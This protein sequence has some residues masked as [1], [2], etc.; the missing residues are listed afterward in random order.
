VVHCRYAHRAEPVCVLARC[1]SLFVRHGRARQL[2]RGAESCGGILCAARSRFC[3]RPLYR[4]R[5][6]RSNSGTSSRG[7]YRIAFRLAACL[8]FHGRCWPALAG[9]LARDLWGLKSQSRSSTRI[10]SRTSVE[11]SPAPPANLAASDSTRPH[12]SRLVLLS[13]LVSEVF[14]GR[15]P[16]IPSINRQ[17]CLGGVSGGGYWMLGRRLFFICVD[18]QRSDSG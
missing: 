12:R 3:H 2:H 13:F 5:D 1:F 11:N 7:V 6:A 8:C 4:R 15:A 18:S 9:P 14:D 10:H 16:S 17:N